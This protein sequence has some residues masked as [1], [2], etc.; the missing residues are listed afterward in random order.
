[1]AEEF[2]IGPLTWVKDEI[3]NSL[4][5]VLDHLVQLNENTGD[6]S[7]VK[8]AKTHLYQASGALDMVGLEGC[9][10]YAAELEN[11]LTKLEQTEIEADQDLIKHLTDAIKV[12]KNYLDALMHGS[13]DQPLRLYDALAPV[14]SATGRQ[15]EKSELFFI[16]A[17]FVAPQD[18]K[19]QELAETDYLALINQ[20]R[21]V[22]QRALLQWLQ[23]AEA[24]PLSSMVEALAEVCYAQTRNAPKTLWWVASAFMQSLSDKAVSAL[25]AAK[26]LCRKVDQE[27]KLLQTAAKANPPM[28]KDMLYYIAVSDVAD[29]NVNKVKET[30]SLMQLTPNDDTAMSAKALTDAE[31]AAVKELVVTIEELDRVWHEISESVGFHDAAAPQVNNVLLTQCVDLLHSRNSLVQQ[32][33]KAIVMDLYN[34]LSQALS[35]VS[36]NQ[37]KLTQAVLIELSAGINLL[38][39]LLNHYADNNDSQTDKILGQIQ[40]LEKIAA[41]EVYEQFAYERTSAL[42][43]EVLQTVIE[44]IKESLTS[45]EQT[46]DAFFR[47]PEDKSHLSMTTKPLDEVVGTFYMLD[48]GVAAEIAKSAKDYIQYFKSEQF[49]SNEGEFELVAESLSM[50]GMYVDEMPNV[51]E[52]TQT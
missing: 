14:V 31:L 12:L 10:F 2:D 37:D 43:P 28:L 42:E 27:L 38:A 11:C 24:A 23:T 44:H 21:M 25:P 51:S 3:D 1:V 5:V 8:G 46:L 33:S 50:L 32:L 48:M 26:R 4:D 41:G 6:I 34:A 29:E 45:V 13:G 18:I 17:S 52:N 22:Y 15:L 19:T 36:A 16:D 39:N 30:F 49:Q 9:K 40:R 20:Q 47:K 35:Y 7:L